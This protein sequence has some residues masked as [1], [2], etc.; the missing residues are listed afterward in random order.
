MTADQQQALALNLRSMFDKIDRQEPIGEELVEIT[1][2]Q[3]EIQ[4]TAP[5]Q[6]THFLDRRSYTKAL[7]Y[8]ES[9]TVIDDPNRPECDDEPNHP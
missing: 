6:L 9:G 2:I 5:P 4:S 8:L 7:E 3:G 1:R